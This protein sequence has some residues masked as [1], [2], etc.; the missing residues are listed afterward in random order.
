MEYN[1]LDSVNT[2]NSDLVTRLQSKFRN[3]PNVTQEDCNDWV[4]DA[5]TLHGNETDTVLV[6]TLAQ[7]IGARSIALNV[8][9][10]F[11]YSDGDESVDKTMLADQYLRIATEFQT[12]YTNNKATVGGNGATFTIVKRADR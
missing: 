10:Y 11:S 1:S 7:A 4:A 9:H 6:L 8:A 2:V 5:V 3:V 12:A